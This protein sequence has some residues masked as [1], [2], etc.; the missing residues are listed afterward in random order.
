MKEN[1]SEAIGCCS[2]DFLPD[3]IVTMDAFGKICAFNR[4]A[5]ELFGYTKEEVVG[6]KI[7]TL[8]PERWRDHVDHRNAY[9]RGRYKC[10][11]NAA[12][13]VTGLHKNGVEFE[14]DVS[15]STFS[16]KDGTFTYAAVRDG[17]L[18]KQARAVLEHTETCFSELVATMNEAFAIGDQAYRFTF[19]NERFCEILGYEHDELIGHHLSDFVDEQDKALMKNQM[20]LRHKGIAENFELAWRAKSGE[21]ICTLACPKG[22]YDEQGRF[23]GSFGVLTDIT[24]RKRKEE[25]LIESEERFRVAFEAYPDAVSINRL[26]DGR[27]IDVNENFTAITGFTKEEVQ[28]KTYADLDIW[29]LETDRTRLSALLR[30]DGRVTNYEAGLR[31]KDG[32]LTTGLVSIRTISLHGAVCTLSIIR[33]IGRIKKTEDELKA[34]NA[35]VRLLLESAGEGIYGVDTEGRCTFINQSALHMIGYT[36]NEVKGNVI[37]EIVCHSHLEGSLNPIEDS[38]VFETFR[39]GTDCR[40]TNEVMW[41]KDGNSFPVEYSS[42]PIHQD[43]ILTGAVVV[44]RDVAETR[45]MARKMDYLATHDKLTGLINRHEFERRLRKAIE[46]A[47]SEDKCHVLCY[48]DLDQFKIVN[49]TCGH[50]AGDELLRQITMLLQRGVRQGDTLARLGGDEFGALLEQRP[51]DK[52]LQIVDKMRKTVEE[53]R[54]TWDERTFVIGVSIGLVEITAD[55]ESIAAAMSAADT[56][57]YVAKDRGRNRIHIYQAD[58]AELAQRH[59]EMQWVSRILNA[60]AHQRFFLSC[61]PIVSRSDRNNRYSHI[62]MLVRMRDEHG[63]VVPPSAFIPA[64]ERYNLMSTVDR[65]VIESTFEWLAGQRELGKHDCCAINLSGNTLNDDYLLDFIVEKFNETKI[66]PE[67]ICFE[68]TETAAVSNLKRVVNLITKLKRIG[69]L[70]ALDDFGSG[71]SSFA[72]LKNLPVDFLKIDGHFVRNI[73]DDTIDYAMVDA[74]NQVGHVMGIKTVAEY[75]ESRS[76]LEKLDMIGVDYVQGYDIAT[77]MTLAEFNQWS[78]RPFSSLGK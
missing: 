63:D 20:Q 76:I 16:T 19:V 53:F 64:A 45:A 54:F 52:A 23:M 72:Y 66:P 61:Q 56:A 30:S 73:A 2:I 50:I 4:R 78:P 38:P 26:E 28:W 31:L 27:F 46:S 14:V 6:Q 15:L 68:I 22:F 58:D 44:F 42:H 8:L 43:G 74:I 59:G 67:T 51:L 47:A 71:M 7:E 70:F 25:E 57:C 32:S 13:P 18:R 55:I 17:T 37:H 3:A 5:E 1:D 34:V 35:H 77:P 69:C 21:K 48:L 49:D 12:R 62:E 9:L 10:C 75:V 36:D 65:W 29:H 39:H 24:D 41:R 40:V 60:L 33:D 11:S